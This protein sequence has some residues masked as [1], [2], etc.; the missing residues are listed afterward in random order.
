MMVLINRK[1]AVLKKGT[2]FEFFEEN[3]FFT[4]ADSYSLSISFPIKGCTENIDIF[5]HIYRKDFDFDTQLMECEIHDR[6]FH[7]YGSVSIVS[8]TDTEVKTQFLEGRSATNF[9][10][11]MDEVFINEIQM[12]SIH[13]PANERTEF[14][15]RSYGEQ[16]VDEENGGQYLGFVCPPWV[17][18]T[19]GNMQ[20]RMESSIN[21]YYYA[22]KRQGYTPSVVGFPFLVEIIRQVMAGMG[23]QCDL[24]AIERS[25]WGNLI[26]CQAFP[27]VWEM[28]YMNQILPHWTVSEFLEQVERFL[29]GSFELDEKGQRMVFSFNNDI[30]RNMPVVTV[31]KVVDSHS[32]DMEVKEK[33]RDVYIEQQNLKYRE[34]GHQMWKFY[35][36]D[37]AMGNMPMT[38]YVNIAAMRNALDG[39]LDCPGPYLSWVYRFVHYCKQEDT[40]FVL[41]CVGTQVIDNAI[42]HHMRYQPV[43]MFAPRNMNRNENAEWVEMG[44]VPACID[45]TDYRHGDMVFVECGTLGDD[46][47]DAEDSDENQTQVVNTLIEGE[48]QKKEEFFDRL[49]VGFWDGEYMDFFPQMPRPYIDKHEFSKEN[50]Y[51]RN[52]YSMRLTGKEVPNTNMQICQ[53]NQQRKFT[54]SFL[55]DSIPDV[56]SIFLIHGKMYLAEKITATFSADTGMSQLMK[57]VCY[58]LLDKG[59]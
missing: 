46:V 49:Y 25:Q 32:V 20:N 22:D 4:G 53:I 2:A 40:Y 50:N 38:T 57:M 36:C 1:K 21:S 19:S 12:P 13:V 10:S 28:P 26:V 56:R 54:F 45:S 44:I 42:H 58:R 34:C 35:A 14:Y 3:R 37:W 52:Q 43:N 16:K 9:H 59:G 15:L 39:Y 11:S 23:Y 51:I 41:K 55:A 47:E 6:H 7:K 18:N 48:K 31:N 17:N 8:A 30:I 29:N 33:G 24:S 27:V 5:G